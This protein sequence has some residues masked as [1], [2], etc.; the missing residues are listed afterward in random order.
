MQGVAVVLLSGGLDSATVLALAQAQGFVCHALSFRYGQ[1]HVQ[2][3]QAAERVAAH[4][5]A[6]SWRTVTL[7]LAPL[8]GSA[9]T[10]PD[11]VVP[12]HRDLSRQET[13]IP[14]TY[15]PARNTLFL[16]Y[17]LA[18]AEVLPAEAIFL[19][20]NALDYS[21]YPDCRPDYL[22]AFRTLARLA[23]RAGV[24]GR[25]IR[26]HAPLLSWDKAMIIRQGLALGVDY[27]LTHS[28]YDPTPEGLACGACDACLLRRRGFAQVGSVDPV[29][30]AA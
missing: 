11:W 2:E 17:A 25:E 12:K 1:R 15:V 18:W 30:Y 6:A 22:E 28:C 24:E 27:R 4:L 14:S 19:G 8:G 7:D 5:G 23:T 10:Q 16:S 9:L 21:G 20:I 13:T 3:L 26:I 29:A